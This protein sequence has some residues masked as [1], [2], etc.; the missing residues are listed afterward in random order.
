MFYLDL[1]VKR[2]GGLNTCVI[3][4]LIWRKERGKKSSFFFL[5]RF[6]FVVIYADTKSVSTKQLKVDHKD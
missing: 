4:N 2:A 1:C 5:K 3:T 6:F